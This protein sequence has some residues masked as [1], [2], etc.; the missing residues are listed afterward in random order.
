[1]ALRTDFELEIIHPTKTELISVMWIEI[2]SMEGSFTVG[3]DHSPLV[4][5]LKP[6]G[7]IKYST[8]GGTITDIT[9]TSGIFSVNKGRAVIIFDH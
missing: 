2:E 6:E 7:Q 1:M 8:L 3:P 5:V 9:I 4:A